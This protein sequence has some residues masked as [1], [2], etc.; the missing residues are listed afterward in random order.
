M[1]KLFILFMAVTLI[2]P[3][4]AC[5]NKA[6]P[7]NGNSGI[8]QISG[9][10]ESASDG[11]NLQGGGLRLL[12]SPYSDSACNT[13]NGYY[14]LTGDTVKLRDGNYGSH[15]M[16][17]DFATCRE[18]YLCSTAG[19][20][21][22][23]LDCP[24][25]FLYDD[26]PLWTTKLF[27][28]GDNLYILSR[29][30]DDD[31]TLMQDI[32]TNGADNEVES[33]PAALYCAK[34]DGTERK[35]V[36]TFDSA[37]TLEDI[38]IGNEQGIYV[39]T[40]KLSTDK[41]DNQIYT[42]SSERKLMFLDLESFSLKEVCEMDFGDYISWQVVGCYRDALVLSGTDFG[43]EISRD[44]K[45]NDDVYKEL[46]ENSSQ[47]YALLDISG[48][49]LKEICRQENRYENS[50]EILGDSLYLSS[51]ES[52]DIEVLN[53]ETGERKTLCSIRQNFIQDGIGDMLCCRDWSLTE[54]Q[55][56]FIN[57][58]TGNITC[59]PLVNR[60][61][62]WAIEFRG[63]TTSDILI[64]YDYDAQKYSDDSYEI[65]RY[66]YALISK[67]DL[68]AGRDDYREIEMIG[69]GL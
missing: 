32:I 11:S 10:S 20:K 8:S 6:N 36:Y 40:K 9:I 62:G 3:L 61:N 19:C 63:E 26:F 56:Y 34:L 18:I 46:Y 35:K 23:S 17:M 13:E 5:G 14:Y 47:V 54:E 50:V 64:V 51:S 42:T 21:H 24:S 33:T 66:K 53:I 67:E 52:E 29:E 45:W 15:L 25:V 31:G 43:K 59:S 41:T 48:G 65:Y 49:K 69:P 60:C 37:L 16:Y 7:S 39:I 68:F 28:F 1:K 27:I 58:E 57:T 2:L 22:D 4:S 38:V 55:Y 44:E 12:C 30:Y